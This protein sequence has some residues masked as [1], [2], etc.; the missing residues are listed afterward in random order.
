MMKTRT[1]IWILS[2]VFLLGVLGSVFVFCRR[3]AER[4]IANIYV[5]GVCV[6]SVDLSS[7][8]EPYEFQVNTAHG[9]NTVRVEQGRIAVISADCTDETCVHTGWIGDR[10]I[11]IVCLPHRLVIRVEQ[12]AAYDVDAVAR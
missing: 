1:W 12:N 9:Y 6:R 8:T 4:R 2:G 11:P 3:P 7:V 10:A 5:D